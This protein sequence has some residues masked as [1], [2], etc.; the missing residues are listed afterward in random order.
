MANAND[1]KLLDYLK[2]VT[3]DLHQTRQRL[4]DVESQESE[5]IAIVGMACR[6]PGGVTSPEELWQ[7][8]ADG[9]DAVSRFPTDRGWDLEALRGGAT[10]TGEGGPE[11]QSGTSYVDEGGFVHDAADFDAGFFGISPR[12]ATATDPQQRMMLEA[13]WEAFE[14]AGIDP[15]TARGRRVGVFAGSGLQDYGYLLDSVPEL[16]ESFLTT[17][18]SAAVISGRVSYTLGLEGPAVTV[19]TACSSSLVALHLAVQSLRRRESTLALA[20]GVMLMATPAPF[21]AFSKQQG[22][23]PDG[24]CK[25]F[26]EDADGTGWSEGVGILLLERLSDARRNGH[27]VL[28]VVRG[29]AVNQDGA[30]NG[31]TAPNG[32]AQ[33]RVIRQALAD[34][35]LTPDQVDAV[36]AHGTGTTLG[37][38]IEAQALLA[39]YGQQRGANGEPLWLGSIKSNIGHAQ[40]AAG[41]GGIIKMVMAMRH[42]VLPR[43]LHAE[44]PSSHIDWSAGAVELLTEARDW[45]RGEQPRRAGVSSFGVSGT[46]A[47]IILEEADA[48][49][50]AEGTEAP[51]ADAGAAADS[52]AGSRAGV[53]PVVLSA[54]TAPALREQAAR[55][56]AHLTAHPEVRVPDVAHALVTA[57]ASFEHR[58]VVAA[59]G[60]E[61]LLTALDRIADGTEPLAGAARPGGTTGFLFTGQGAQRLGMGQELYNAHPVFAARFDEVCT[62]LDRWLDRPL[63]EVIWGEDSDLLNQTAYTQTALFAVE[64]ALFALL[65]S[66][67]VRPQYLAGHSIGELAAAHVAGVWTLPDAARLVAARGKLMQAL[68]GGGAMIAIEAT[69]AEVTAHLIKGVDIAALNGP[70]SVVISGDSAAVEALA[71][72]FAAQGRRT[73][74]LRVSHAFHSVLMEPMLAEYATVARELAYNEPTIPLVSTVT[75]TLATTELTDPQYWVDQVRAAVRF[76]DAVQTLADNGVT[77]LLEVGPDAVLTAMAQQTLDDTTVIPT[78]RRDRDE[79]RTLL[80]ALGSLHTTGVT[81]DWATAFTGLHTQHTD[82]PT[83]PFQHERYWV[84]SRPA[85][86]DVRA[87]GLDTAD[88]PLLGAAVVLADSDGVVLTGRLSVD[89]QPWLA[90]HRV[91]DTVL[92]PGTGFVELALRAGQQV[93]AEALAE[94]TLHAP[95]VLPER[96]AVA[97]QVVVGPADRTGARTISVHSRLQS[98]STGAP[99]T[100]H[101]TGVLA[102]GARRAGTELTAW[103]PA[104]AQPVD[105]DGLYEDF[106]RVGLGYGPVFQGLKAAW[107]RGGELFAELALPESAH[108]DA[109]RFGVHPALLD[110]AM[111][112]AFFAELTGEQ[113]MVPFTWS[114]VTLH[115]VGAAVARVRLTA[116]AG[117]SLVLDLADATGR[118]VASVGSVA[119]R[120]ISAEQV[121]AARALVHDSLFT[122]RWQQAAVP[123]APPTAAWARWED[124]AGSDTPPAVLVLEVD[125]GSDAAAVHTATGRTLTILQEWLSD[126]RFTDSRLLVVTRGAVALPGADDATRI[127]LAQAALRGLVRAAQSENPGRIVQLDL[128]AAA[129]ADATTDF[130]VAASLATEESELA[131]RDGEFWIPRLT[132][133]TV[134][135]TT[136]DDAPGKARPASVF[137]AEGAVLITGG[138]GGLGALLARHLVTEHGV[139]RLVLTS[140]RGPEAPGATELAA[141][142]TALGAEVDV[143]ACDVADRDALAD[144]LTG[145]TARGTE[146][147]GVVHAAGVLGDGV[148]ASLTPE[149]LSQVLSA[150]VDS[151]L[152]LHELTSD[153]DLSAF[154]LFSSVAGT[155]G[156]PGQ[157]NYAAANVFLDALAAHRRA[158]GLAAQSLAWGLWARA[159]AM[160]GTLTGV[161]RTRMSQG[162]VIP[163]ADDEGL[164]LFDTAPGVD[165]A[166]VVPA[167]LD[168]PSLRA[169]G[170]ALPELLRDLVPAAPRRSSDAASD[171]TSG[172]RRQLSALPEEEWETAL[173]ELVRTRTAAVLGHATADSI[174]P[175]RAFQELGFD[176]LTAVEFRNAMNDA[177]GLRLPTSL[178]FDYPSP[179]A[180]ARHL[181]TEVADAA[182]AEAGAVSVGVVGAVDDDPIAIIG[183]ACRYPG[184]IT[185]P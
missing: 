171:E 40:A 120:P 46:N 78:Q 47:H 172:L 140:R 152:H 66:W 9:T 132:R 20:G 67:G 91:G 14:R 150:K 45:P 75:G 23:A 49:P 86:G 96:G 88:H 165:A 142:L 42:G 182:G 16:A 133:A 125:G 123:T 77:T 35:R 7:L 87:A 100:R 24:R 5:P 119:L 38:P 108:A 107:R 90:H 83:Y 6:Y 129:T 146:L 62:E 56:H 80:A 124:A 144:L 164:S 58:A 54:K 32:P 74:K 131:H 48:A 76:T 118:P 27:P 147:R 138:T 102:P 64:V 101:A 173:L 43:T 113:A 3:A 105:A 99:W 85:A 97:V 157:G 12:E 18:S 22:L 137:G 8:V 151:A 19:D 71:E 180:L 89:A 175:E 135:G 57:R 148:I 111:H 25:A 29:S 121:S 1:E 158:H 26:S 167:R 60:R 134:A 176:S 65:D 114:D 122:L 166:V 79:T 174:D 72:R 84:K 162:G 98:S 39:T 2:R 93:R 63:R 70:R 117:G 169:Q 139:R 149:S 168:F 112:P 153:L 161:D 41:V 37:D 145:L 163:L 178:V 21:I 52:D 143:E 177:T 73:S 44:R 159:S 136:G 15:T 50:V 51:V 156:A 55:L 92:F 81:I 61:E 53:L 82:L 110:A 109:A 10:G 141:E 11:A 59:A 36:E 13:C 17:A 95:L 106:A 184:D 94:L 30:S 4:Q 127:D 28:A 68:P 31:L 170:D 126:A 130:L 185:T 183:M 128:D 69:E 155:L 33:Q 116:S 103:P 181:L 160:T 115:A 34:A 179:V 154:V 104:G